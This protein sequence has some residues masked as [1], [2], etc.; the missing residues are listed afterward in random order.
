MRKKVTLVWVTLVCYITVAFTINLPINCYLRA[1]LAFNELTV[2][3]LTQNKFWANAL[4]I[5]L[6]KQPFCHSE[7]LLKIAAPKSS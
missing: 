5:I 2:L 7:V 1:T 4:N 6:Q 3:A